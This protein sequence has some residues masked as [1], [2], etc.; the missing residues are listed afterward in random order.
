M[1]R[2]YNKLLA[3]CIVLMIPIGLS[4]ES[5]RY[6][7]MLGSASV[8][9]YNAQ[10]GDNVNH[11][12]DFTGAQLKSYATSG[13]VTV[14]VKVT[15]SENNST[16]QLG[17][18]TTTTIVSGTTYNLSSNNQTTTLTL[19]LS[20]ADASYDNYTFQFVSNSNERNNAKLIV[21]HTKITTYELS[22]DG[23]NSWRSVASGQTVYSSSMPFMLR[24]AIGSTYSYFKSDNGSLVS[25]TQATATLV[26]DKASATS[27]S[28]TT[29]SSYGFKLNFTDNAVTLTDNGVGNTYYLV[30]PELT[31]NE[32]REEFRLIPSRKRNGGSL[33]TRLFSLNVKNERIKKLAG[34]AT[35]IHY[36]IVKASDNT[37][38]RPYKTQETYALGETSAATTTTH[39][40]NGN[41]KQETYNNTVEGSTTNYFTLTVGNGVSY[42]WQF[43][44]NGK[45]A[46]TRLTNLHALAD[47]ANKTFYLIGNFQDADASIKILPYNE[48]SRAKLNRIVYKH[49]KPGVGMPDMTTEATAEGVDSVVYRV[50]VP[51]PAKGWGELYMAVAGENL[52]NN[53]TSTNWGINWDHIIRP[54]VQGY[55]DNSSNTEG[56]DATALHG[57]LFQCNGKGKYENNSQALNPQ[58]T[59]EYANAT[60]YTFSMNIT[61]STYRIS[62]NTK[63]MYIMGTAVSASN[64]NVENVSGIEGVTSGNSVRALPLTW[65]NDEQCFKYMVNGEETAILMNNDET[66]GNRFRFVYNKDFK[67]PWFGEN[68]DNTK[69]NSSENPNVPADLTTSTKPYT[70]YGDNYD[71]QY[72]NYLNTYQSAENKYNDPTKDIKFQL[73]IKSDGTGYIIRFYM[74]KIGDDV[75]YFYTINRKIGFHDF[76]AP[77]TELNNDRYFRSFSEWHACKIPDGVDHVYIVTTHPTQSNTDIQEGVTMTDISSLGYIPAREGVILGASDLSTNKKLVFETYTENPE[78]T[79]PSTYTNYLKAAIDDQPIYVENENYTYNNFVFDKSDKEGSQAGFYYP[80]VDLRSGRNNCFLQLDRPTSSGGAKAMAGLMAFFI[81]ESVNPVVTGLEKI[82]NDSVEE[83]DAPYYTLQ[84]AK[85]SKPNGRGIYIHNGKKIIVR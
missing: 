10:L 69:A 27:Y 30:S 38:Y 70:A 13:K 48:N 78:A 52:I 2:L 22:S 6:E 61:T 45:H 1:K 37:I 15:Y 16:Y 4:A 12:K 43:D 80:L 62:F 21:T 5:W 41:V 18:A 83:N 84:G 63:Q 25:G 42:T 58:V 79:L 47:N 40:A 65:D 66:N 14:K 75:K 76:K 17:N 49:D 56:M 9:N 28:V 7:L 26:S 68:A 50:S 85:L 59:S 29:E 24:K 11:T 54:Q 73:P 46:L 53:S 44:T 55:N 57:G 51:R 72:V 33:S 74:K 34:S 77:V 8:A 81:G 19:D 23:G 39:T 3:L 32:M 36:Y 82:E 60:S 71:T 20:G 67:N 31:N 64:A 35:T